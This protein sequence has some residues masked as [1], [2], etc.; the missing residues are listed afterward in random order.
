[1]SAVVK[2]GGVIDT[3]APKKQRVVVEPIVGL[4]QEE[5]VADGLALWL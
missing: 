2:C 5:P 3:D 1:M 4:L